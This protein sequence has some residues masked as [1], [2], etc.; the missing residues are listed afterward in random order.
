MP[1]DEGHDFIIVSDLHMS[2]GYDPRVGAFHLQEDFFNDAAFARFLDNLCERAGKERRKWRLLILGDLFDFARVEL[3]SLR[4]Q[5]HHDTSEKITLAKLN[6][7]AAGH[8]EFFEA[9]GRFVAE[10]FQL[11]LVP[12]NHDIDLMRPSAQ[13]RFKELVAESCDRPEVK[14]GITFHAWIYF[15]P[16]VLYAEHGHQY[17]DINWWP[18]LLRPY[19]PDNPGTIELPL[20]PQFEQYLFNLIKAIDPSAEEVKQPLRYILRVFKAR[21]VAALATWREHV[22]FA[23]TVSSYLANLA[24]V[25]LARRRAAYHEEALQPYA[26]LS[27]LTYGA[28][29]A[30]DEVAAVTAKSIKRRLLGKLLFGPV[31]R[32]LPSLGALAAMYTA[33]RR[34]P[35]S[36]GSFVMFAAG[37]LGLARREGRFVP[38]AARSST[39]LRDVPLKVDRV[40]QAANQGVPYY[41]FGHTHIAE[42]FPVGNSVASYLNSGTWINLVATPDTGRKPF[43]FVQITREPATG[44]PIGRLLVWNDAAGR[45]EPLT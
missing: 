35:A 5:D 27:G 25:E 31:L 39:Y 14:T 9:L 4:T 2:S 6:R 10:G 19:Q 34:V 28:V 21:P 13:A 26:A 20:A 38:S 17:H 11:D 40:L 1:P 15:V 8:S 41:V 45:P 43:T 36:S 12:G 29:V 32:S 42:Q 24:S 37:A 16:G 23:S 7:I 44:T 22:R 18:T 3:S 33:L 30:I